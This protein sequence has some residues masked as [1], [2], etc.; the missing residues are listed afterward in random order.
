MG[1]KPKIAL[2][3]CAGCGGCEESVIDLANGLLTVAQEAEIVFWPVAMDAR[4]RD[5]EALADGSIAAS[6]INGAIR[7]DDHVR[8]VRL[9]RRKSKL[10]IA[11]GTC[12]HM[13]GVVGLANLFTP[14]QLLACAYREVPSMAG[15]AGPL[16]GDITGAKKDEILLPGLLPAVKTLDQVVPVDAFIPGCPPLPETMEQV[17]RD[18][19]ASRLPEKGTVFAHRKALCDGCPRRD[20]IPDKIEISRFKRLY[21][22]DWDPDV[23]FLPQGL[24]CLGPVTR[25]GCAARCIGANMPCRGC[26]GPTERIDD[27][28]AGAIGLIAA[29]MAGTDEPALAQLTESIADPAGLIYRYSLATSV[30]GKGRSS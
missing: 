19:I 25:G 6:F 29:M 24:I 23:C 26:F 16:P 1:D 22:T 7:L 14:R 2:Y 13:G 10:I 12:A 15:P 4:Y 28:G 5:L 20:S 8:M 18:V 11:H 17:I 30:L 27:F 9:L 21:E 3:W